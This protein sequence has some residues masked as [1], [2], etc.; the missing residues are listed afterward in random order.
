[1]FWGFWLFVV[2]FIATEPAITANSPKNK[3]NRVIPPSSSRSG[4]VSSSALNHQLSYN[5][6][7]NA[8]ATVIA[9]TKINNT[10]NGHQSNSKHLVK[11]GHAKR[12]EIDSS[13]S[14]AFSELQPEGTPQIVDTPPSK[15]FE[16][17][18]KLF[19]KLSALKLNGRNEVI[20]LPGVVNVYGPPP[21]SLGEGL[22]QAQEPL[23]VVASPHLT[24]FHSYH[25]F[26]LLPVTFRGGEVAPISL[27]PNRRPVEIN[28]GRPKHLFLPFSPHRRRNPFARF[29]KTPARPVL[30]MSTNYLRKHS[31]YVHLLPHRRIFTTGAYK[32]PEFRAQPYEE[33]AALARAALPIALPASPRVA[34]ARGGSS[35]SPELFE[36]LRNANARPRYIE[37]GRPVE[38]FMPGR[39]VTLAANEDVDMR[40]LNLNK[41]GMFQTVPTD[42]SRYTGEENTAP[43][44]SPGVELFTVNNHHHHQEELTDRD[45]EQLPNTIQSPSPAAAEVMDNHE[46]AFGR[47]L[48]TPNMDGAAPF[49]TS[50]EN[51]VEPSH[52]ILTPSDHFGGL[53]SEGNIGNQHFDD[54]DKHAVGG[55]ASLFGDLQGGA[56]AGLGLNDGVE[57]IQHHHTSLGLHDTVHHHHLSKFDGS[58]LIRGFIWN[59][60]KVTHPLFFKSLGF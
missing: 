25:R 10:V 53:G 45:V 39:E 24:K 21:K 30:P 33:E 59:V 26:N 49:P 54:N 36:A 37:A 51:E 29:Y 41:E 11:I 47:D 28:T 12:A 52:H 23:N 17:S 27:Y 20:T 6:L 56:S 32:Q 19:N 7:T 31:R 18:Q 2:C 44:N 16:I 8:T 60:I 3:P 55:L 1:M 4:I 43:Q 15:K 57:G 50:V 13:L 34:F 38:K 40:H 22:P 58:W 9:R 5:Q 46:P 35:Q 14:S 42:M 48:N